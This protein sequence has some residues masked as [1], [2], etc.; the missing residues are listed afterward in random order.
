MDQ[1]IVSTGKK[2]EAH[3]GRDVIR[4]GGYFNIQ[5]A[6]LLCRAAGKNII[7]LSNVP[8]GTETTCAAYPKSSQGFPR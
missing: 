7:K 6:A 5:P 8:M 3:L 2:G 1:V 4:F